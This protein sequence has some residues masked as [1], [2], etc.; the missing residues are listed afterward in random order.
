MYQRLKAR[1]WLWLYVS[2]GNH[3]G[4]DADEYWDHHFDRVVKFRLRE[5]RGSSLGENLIKEL[6]WDVPDRAPGAIERDDFRDSFRNTRDT[7]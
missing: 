7:R 6:F 5:I 1:F 3:V 2:A 4:T